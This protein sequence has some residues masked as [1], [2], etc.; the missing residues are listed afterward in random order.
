M[1][2][3]EFDSGVYEVLEIKYN[4]F[5]PKNAVAFWNK[6]LSNVWLQSLSYCE[7]APSCAALFLV[8]SQF[9]GSLT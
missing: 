8:S 3:L 5:T 2:K 6:N 1:T 4:F 7:A 9:E